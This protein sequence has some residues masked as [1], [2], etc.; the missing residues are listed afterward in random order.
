MWDVYQIKGLTNM[1][2]EASGA[3][4]V[5][6]QHRLWLVYQER[7]CCVQLQPARNSQPA[8]LVIITS[9]HSPDQEGA[10]V[11]LQNMRMQLGGSEVT[12]ASWRGVSTS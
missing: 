10:Q 12:S 3:Y 1:M 9:S 8:E 4:L 11:L 2:S 6:V 5:G 7:C